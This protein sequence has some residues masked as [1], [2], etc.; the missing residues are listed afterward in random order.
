MLKGGK[1]LQYQNAAQILPPALL[2]AVQKYVSGTL[3]YIPVADPGRV[4]WGGANG[5]KETYVSRNREIR[6]LYLAG[7]SVRNIGKRFYL[8]ADSVKKI[9]NK[10]A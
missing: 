6:R 4:G 2:K 1:P 9:V 7:E 8:S 3:V 5:A 10:S